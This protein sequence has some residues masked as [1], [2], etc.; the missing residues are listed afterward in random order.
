MLTGHNHY[1]MC[2]SFHPSEDLI[3]SAS[4]DQVRIVWKLAIEVL[5]LTVI[6]ALLP[7]DCSRLGHDWA[8]E[9]TARWRRRHGFPGHARKWVQQKRRVVR[10]CCDRP[11]CPGGTLRHERRR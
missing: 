10:C 11:E 8:Q 4:L 7:L 3:V 2:A 9:E 1:V 5:V 6:C